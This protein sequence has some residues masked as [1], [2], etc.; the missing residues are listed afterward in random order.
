MDSFTPASIATCSSQRREKHETNHP[1]PPA[2][3][4]ISHKRLPRNTLRTPCKRR[5]SLLRYQRH[6]TRKRPFPRTLPLAEVRR[7]I[8]E[9]IPRKH[10]LGNCSQCWHSLQEKRAPRYYRGLPAYWCHDQIENCPHKR[11]NRKGESVCT[12]TCSKQRKE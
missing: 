12:K 7:M 6:S 9:Y 3:M 10:L 11:T 2:A 1:K 4:P 8:Q 5:P